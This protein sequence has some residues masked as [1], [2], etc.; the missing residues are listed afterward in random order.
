[1][2]TPAIQRRIL[3]VLADAFT[4]VRSVEANRAIAAV[5]LDQLI[6]DQIKRNGESSDSNNSRF[7][8]YSFDPNATPPAGNQPITAAN[9][10]GGADT[11]APT[12]IA[13]LLA[14]KNNLSAVV[15]ELKKIPAQ[16]LKDFLGL[17]VAEQDPLLTLEEEE[18]V[19]G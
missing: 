8:P 9:F 5:T 19:G 17:E 2:T 7:D 3:N 4:F 6:N 13:R 14:I 11:N 1:M 16:D 15:T 18:I 10:A 12:K